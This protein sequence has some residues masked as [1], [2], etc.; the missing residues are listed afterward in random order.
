MKRTPQGEFKVP[1][2]VYLQA[3]GDLWFRFGGTMVD[4]VPFE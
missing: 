2:T 1:E 3:V 4:R